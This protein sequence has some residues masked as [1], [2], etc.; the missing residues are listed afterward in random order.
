M[1]RP[2]ADDLATAMGKSWWLLLLRGLVAI[3]FALLTWL[4]PAASLAAMVLVFGIYVLADGVLGI[5]AALSG[6]KVNLLGNIIVTQVGSLKWAMAS[7]VGVIL[8]V[9]MGIVIAGFLRIVDLKREL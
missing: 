5:W 8:T 9:V 6:R 2:N 3:V 1:I 4:Q 7:V